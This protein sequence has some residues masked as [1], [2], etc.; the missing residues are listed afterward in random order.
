M[1]DLFRRRSCGGVVP[2]CAPDLGAGRVSNR[3]GMKHFAQILI[4]LAAVCPVS[5]VLSF[6]T[7]FW[8]WQ[9]NEPP[10][11]NDRAELSSEGV[12]TLYWQLGQL[13]NTHDSWRWKARFSLPSVPN[14]AVIPVLRLESRARSPFAPAAMSSLLPL[15]SA[16]AGGGRELQID[17][18]CPDRLL[19]EYANAL[20]QIRKLVPGL[21]ITALPGWIRQPAFTELAASVAEMFPMFYDFAPDPVVPGAGPVPVIVPENARAW[22]A[23]WNRCQTPWHAGLPN[24]ARLTVYDLNGKSR[25]HIREWNWDSV[26]FNEALVLERAT[27]LGLTLFRARA[28]SRI[29]NTPLHDQQLLAVR[30]PDRGALA[31]LIA[32]A[33]KTSARGM[34]VFRLPDSTAASGW[35]LRQL[36]H[37]SA[38]PHLTLKKASDSDQ[39][40]LTNE[41]DADLEPVFQEGAEPVGYILQIEAERPIFREAEEGDFWRVRGEIARDSQ[42]SAVMIPL[43]TRLNFSFSHLRAGQSLKSGL[44]RLAPGADFAQTRFRIVHSAQSAW[45][46]FQE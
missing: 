34:V 4:A 2:R 22:L 10:S 7:S 11:E 29:G 40:E 15:I 8:A 21:S 9:R 30:W 36:E 42:A 38:T 1:G 3:S 27:A 46:S 17:Y 6:E 13:E 28:N 45:K 32:A 5:S 37:L 16:A 18:D 25:G 33:K 14:I 43:A 12:K 23:E 39:V 24:F 20:K 19:P 26:S 41:G 35:S 44:I 31:D